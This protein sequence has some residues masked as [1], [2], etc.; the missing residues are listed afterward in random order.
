MGSGLGPGYSADGGQDGHLNRR[1]EWQGGYE[2]GPRCGERH[3]ELSSPFNI[4]NTD[5][6]MDLE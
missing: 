5:S 1:W 4:R 2:N 6:R 3:A